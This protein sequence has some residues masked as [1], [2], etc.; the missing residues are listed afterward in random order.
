M[1]DKTDVIAASPRLAGKKGGARK[2]RQRGGLPAIAY[3]PA[4]ATRLLALTPKDF[5]LSRRHFGPSHIYE[6]AG[7]QVGRFKALIKRIDVDPISQQPVHVDFYEVDMAR[8]LRVEVPIELAGK[9]VGLIDGGLLSQVKRS[10]TIL[11]LPGE[12]PARLLVD[13]TP[14]KVGDSLHLSDVQLPAGVRLTAHDNDAVAL[15]V[16][17]D[18]APAPEAAATTAASGTTGA[19]PAAAPTPKK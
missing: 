16:E 4:S 18:V 13:V 6:V 7:D 19:S 2:L 1:A 10:V 9:P 15:L 5:L 3:G 12:V 17:P 11:A 14:L 8:P